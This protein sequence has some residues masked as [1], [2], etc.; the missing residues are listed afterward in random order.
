MS[1][2]QSSPSLSSQDP[3]SPA[4]KAAHTQVHSRG[5]AELL[6]CEVQ[7]QW[8]REVGR[9]ARGHTARVGSVL[10]LVDGQY[11]PIAAAAGKTAAHTACAVACEAVE[12]A[13][14]DARCTVIA[15]GAVL[16]HHAL[17]WPDGIAPEQKTAAMQALRTAGIVVR[18]V[19]A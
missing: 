8:S 5:L 15:R 2:P 13:A 3:G 1:E 16:A 6:I 4:Q 18:E 9:L 19:I 14:A 11:Q 17:V 10:A 7:A 12:A